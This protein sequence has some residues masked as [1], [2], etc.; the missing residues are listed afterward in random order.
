MWL[1]A[2]SA[3]SQTSRFDWQAVW[4]A[5]AGVRRLAIVAVAGSVRYRY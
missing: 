3:A 5:V 4:V 1:A 2:N